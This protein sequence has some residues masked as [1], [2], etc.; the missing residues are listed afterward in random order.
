LKLRP[1]VQIGFGTSGPT[2][3]VNARFAVRRLILPV[4]IVLAVAGQAAM[5][6]AAA[7]E[8][9]RGLDDLVPALLSA[10]VNI[11]S[12]RFL[13]VP[14]G[15]SAAVAATAPRS[16]QSLGSGFIVDSTGFIVTINM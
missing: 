4:A 14:D 8:P 9:I 10:V 16:K 13:P 6:H 12:T 5:S 1:L 7:G 2:G 3:R 11:S 15:P